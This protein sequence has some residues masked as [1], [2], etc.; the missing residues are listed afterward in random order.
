MTSNLIST[1]TVNNAVRVTFNAFGRTMHLE[2]QDIVPE[3]HL[4]QVLKRNLSNVVWDV[5]FEQYVTELSAEAMEAI[6][7]ERVGDWR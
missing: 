6:L 3:E 2:V 5:V 1:F 7:K 4:L